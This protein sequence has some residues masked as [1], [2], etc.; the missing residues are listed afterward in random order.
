MAKIL[1]VEDKDSLRKMLVTALR[2]AGLDI[3][4]ATN[5]SEAVT[6]LENMEFDLI[7]TDLKLPDKNGI[8]VVKFVNRKSLDIPIFII[9]AYGTTQTAIKAFKEGVVEFLEKPLDLK[10]LLQLI[11]EHTLL[12]IEKIEGIKIVGKSQNFRKVLRLAQKVARTNSTVLLLGESGTGKELFA[13]IIH[14]LSQRKDKPFIPI[15]CSAIPK[16][17]VESELFGHEKGAFTGAT[18]RRLGKFVQADKGTLFLDEIGD[19]DLSAQ[20]K[21]LRVIEDGIVEPIG[22][23]PRKVDVRVIAATNKD[24]DR[25][26][27]DGTFRKDLF[28]RLNVFPIRIPPLRERKEDI[29]LLAKYAIIKVTKKNKLRPPTLTDE[30][31]EWLKQKRWEGNVRELLNFIER[32]AII[33]PGK[34]IKVKDLEKYT[35]NDLHL[36]DERSLIKELLIKYKGNRVEV[37]KELGMSLR[38]LQRKIKNYGLKSVIYELEDL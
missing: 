15:N 36:Q 25:S 13:K 35:A 29:P 17:L 26:I 12:E 3:S 9:T 4:E 14:S 31:I 22:G 37:A 38:T 30:A 24:L 10:R 32:I 6:L 27:S 7:I 20:T 1:L 18:S 21:L 16:E 33:N 8:E 34:A 28:F 11:K 19:L 23:T 5:Y 2:K